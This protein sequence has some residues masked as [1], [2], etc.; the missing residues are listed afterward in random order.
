ML[1]NEFLRLSS[2][3]Y[4]NDNKGTVFFVFYIINV[5]VF[6]ISFFY[7]EFNAFM[8]K[9]KKKQEMVSHQLKC[10]SISIHNNNNSNNKSALDL[11]LLSYKISYELLLNLSKL[12]FMKQMEQQWNDNNNVLKKEDRLN[13]FICLLIYKALIKK[14]I[15]S[16]FIAS[17]I[18]HESN[19]NVVSEKHDRFFNVLQQISMV[20]TLGFCYIKIINNKLLITIH[21]NIGFIKKCINKQPI[22]IYQN[23]QL[24][25]N[26]NSYVIIQQSNNNNKKRNMNFFFGIVSYNQKYECLEVLLDSH[27]IKE[28]FPCDQSTQFRMKVFS[29]KLSQIFSSFL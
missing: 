20:K 5:F 23:K 16:T 2:D 19:D 26:Q 10:A 22:N 6:C 24:F 17:E 9:K 29:F 15:R 13:Y 8:H 4:K 3:Y 12:C 28:Y 14:S 21:S 18:Q 1:W 27:T 7:S 11:K 25:N